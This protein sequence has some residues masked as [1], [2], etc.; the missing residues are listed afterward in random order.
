M[1]SS[2]SSYGA[3][4]EEPCHLNAYFLYVLDFKSSSRASPERTSRGSK[5]TT[6][7]GDKMVRGL[8][9]LCA[10]GT[11]SVSNVGDFVIK[12]ARLY[13]NRVGNWTKQTLVGPVSR[14]VC[15]ELSYQFW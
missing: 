13:T 12:T 4:G 15:V 7:L 2:E 5:K 1:G 6:E 14:F 10:R 8:S 3:Y 11:C 9:W